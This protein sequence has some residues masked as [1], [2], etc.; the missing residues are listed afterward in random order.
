MELVGKFKEWMALF[1][2]LEIPSEVWVDG[3]FVCDKPNPSDID[4][5]VLM[6]PGSINAL[7]DEEREELSL[8]FD[9]SN[10]RHRYGLDLY[11]IP[12]D[13]LHQAAYWRGLFG[14][15]HD[16]V[17]PKGFWSIPLPA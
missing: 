2:R 11:C 12:N 4:V 7:P 1:Q 9:R 16:S 13:D 8:L 3:S 6:D 17:T 15:M 14:F 10:A 5:V